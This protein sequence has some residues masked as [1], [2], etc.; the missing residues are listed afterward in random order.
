[1]NQEFANYRISLKGDNYDHAKP[2]FTVIVFDY[3]R[4]KYTREAIES[5][6]NQSISKDLMELLILTDDSSQDFSYIP[7]TVP[8]V[9]YYTGLTIFG[10]S[11]VFGLQ[12]ARGEVICLLD[13]DDKWLSKKLSTLR[14]YFTR[15]P[16]VGFIKDEVIPIGNEKEKRLN[17]RFMIGMNIPKKSPIAFYILEKNPPNAIFG[18]ALTH[19]NSSMSI[20]RKSLNVNFTRLSKISY[21]QDVTIFFTMALNFEYIAFLDE[22]LTYYREA[23]NKAGEPKNNGQLVYRREIFKKNLEVFQS[24]FN[25]RITNGDKQYLK[26]MYFDFIIASKMY[27]NAR[28][29][30]CNYISKKEAFTMFTRSIQTK[31]LNKFLLFFVYIGSKIFRLNIVGS[32]WGAE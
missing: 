31:S 26:S 24:S 17:L 18:R 7:K 32:V 29:K 30:E 23:E 3:I 27:L 21:F 8:Y 28:Y 22:H 16:E 14:L 11:L 1:M 9:V 2:F 15:F 12:I 25:D 20:R 5:A 10:E 4:H 13:N 19:N 6:I